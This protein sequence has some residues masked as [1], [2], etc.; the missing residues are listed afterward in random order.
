[1][2]KI[3]TSAF[4]VMSMNSMAG[5]DQCKAPAQKIIDLIPQF[6]VRSEIKAAR[7]EKKACVQKYKKEASREEK[8]AFRIWFL[9]GKLGALQLRKVNCEKAGKKCR[10]ID[11]RIAK[12]TA[13][14]EKVKSK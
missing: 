4:I 8:K 10:K 7:A 11:S 5:L 2:K 1:M 3:I 13:K 14:L 6:K 12:I 9:E